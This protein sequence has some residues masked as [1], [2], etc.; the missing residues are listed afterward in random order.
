LT[1]LPMPAL[2]LPMRLALLLTQQVMLL[3][4]LLM[5]LHRPMPLRRLMPLHRPPLRLRNPD[6]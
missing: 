4:P 2:P 6:T 1:L 3:A 5:Q